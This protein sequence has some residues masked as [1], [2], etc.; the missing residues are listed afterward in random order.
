MIVISFC[1]EK[2]P[3]CNIRIYILKQYCTFSPSHLWL[4]CHVCYNCA[5]LIA[6][7]WFCISWSSDR[8][9]ERTHSQTGHVWFSGAQWE[10]SEWHTIYIR[11]LWLWNCALFWVHITDKSL[12]FC[13][14]FSTWSWCVC[15]AKLWNSVTASCQAVWVYSTFLLM[16]NSALFLWDKQTWSLWEA[17]LICRTP[18]ARSKS[19]CCRRTRE[20][21]TR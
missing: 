11:I 8:G 10:N 12:F 15:C 14:W 19:Y 6:A 17:A 2:K 13:L 4:L 5:H 9:S 3:K 7:E 21:C 1:S 18:G 20:R 16:R